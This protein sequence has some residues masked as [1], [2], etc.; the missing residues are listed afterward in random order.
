MMMMTAMS[1]GAQ[2]VKVQMLLRGGDLGASLGELPL[3]LGEPAGIKPLQAGGD[4][5]AHAGELATAKN[6]IGD[7]GEEPGPSKSPL[8]Q[9][10]R[11]S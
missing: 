1:S 11:V 4:A 10:G 9:Y 8:Q 5:G 3:Q 7:A 2:A 6:D